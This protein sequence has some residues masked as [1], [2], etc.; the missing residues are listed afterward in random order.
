MIHKIGPSLPQ[1]LAPSRGPGRSGSAGRVEPVRD[2][3]NKGKPVRGEGSGW[4]EQ[5]RGFRLGAETGTL[6]RDGVSSTVRLAISSYL[7]Q[8]SLPRL[9]QRDSLHAML[10]VDLYA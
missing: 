8:E 7:F 10:G 3:E 2:V 1:T 6:A 9:E 4:V 5:L